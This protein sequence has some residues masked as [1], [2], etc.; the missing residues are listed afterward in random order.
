MPENPSEEIPQQR[1]KRD[2][3]DVEVLLKKLLLCSGVISRFSK[4]HEG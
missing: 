4:T 1:N 3:Y 2:D